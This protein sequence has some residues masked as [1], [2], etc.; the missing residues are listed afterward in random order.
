MTPIK[1]RFSC[2]MD[3]RMSPRHMRKSNVEEPSECRQQTGLAPTKP[4][5][6]PESR[7]PNFDFPQL[8]TGGQSDYQGNVDHLVQL[9]LPKYYVLEPNP[10]NSPQVP[11]R[12]SSVEV[13][14][15]VQLPLP[16]Y[17]VLERNSQTP[18]LILYPEY[19]EETEHLD[20]TAQLPLPKD[21][22]LEPDFQ[23]RPQVTYTETSYLG[24]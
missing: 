13:D 23:N 8:P 5:T 2:P 17:Y 10:D 19:P 14:H 15:S 12:D 20:E 3:A 9:P 1:Q 22:V 18:P 6:L 24:V 11:H 21:Y 16:K 7:R 4:W